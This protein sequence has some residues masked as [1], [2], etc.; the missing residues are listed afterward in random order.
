MGDSSDWIA[1]RTIAP[2]PPS[3]TPIEEENHDADHESHDLAHFRN[4]ILDVAQSEGRWLG[5]DQATQRER[6]PSASRSDHLSI[7]ENLRKEGSR[8]PQLRVRVPSPQPRL[9]APSPVQRVVR[10]LNVVAVPDLQRQPSARSSWV[11]A[12][13]D[14]PDSSS[15]LS[16]TPHSPY[17]PDPV[18][19]RT[20]PP[21]SSGDTFEYL[22]P[23]SPLEDDG[24]SDLENQQNM[25]LSGRTC[26][27]FGVQSNLRRSLIVLL[28]SKGFYYGNI[29]VTLFHMVLLI[30]ET[31]SIYEPVGVYDPG[32]GYQKSW[33][34]IVYMVLFSVYTLWLVAYLVAF[35]GF[36]VQYIF[37]WRDAADYTIQYFRNMFLKKRE[38]SF[39]N[40]HCFF[41]K[42]WNRV[43][44]AGIICYWAYLASGKHE[45]HSL[46]RFLAGLAHLRVLRLLDFFENT[47]V[48]LQALKTALPFLQNV[49]LFIGF[50]LIVFAITGLQSF[51]TS[52]QRHCV[53]FDPQDG[54]NYTTSQKC[55]SWFDGSPGSVKK[56]PYLDSNMREGLTAK[57]F[58]CPLNS[59]CIAG[60]NP[61]GNTV[62]FD[63]FFN[64]LE[65]VFVIM[66][67]NTYSDIMY[68]IMDSE[69]LVSCLFFIS[70]VLV[71][72]I[73]LMNLLVA[74]MLSSFAAVRESM[75]LS[76]TRSLEKKDNEWIYKRNIIGKVYLW[77]HPAI[78][79]LPLVDII[80]QARMDYMKLVQWEIALAVVFSCEIVA[81]FGIFLPFW[82]H[83]LSESWFDC[84]LALANI[85]ILP[86]YKTQVYPWLTVIQLSRA[87]RCV[88]LF[89]FARQ[90]WDQLFGDYMVIINL[91]VFYFSLTFLTSLILVKI[92]RGFFPPSD[93]GNLDRKSFFSLSASFLNM[94][95]I[96]STENWTDIL[97]NA[98]SEAGGLVEAICLGILFCL[99]LAFSNF[100]VLNLFIATMMESMS[101][102]VAI[103]RREQ[104]K[105]FTRELMSYLH[106][107]LTPRGVRVVVE[108]MRGKKSAEPQIG[109]N[110][111]VIQS[112]ERLCMAEFL[113][114]NVL[115]EPKPPRRMTTLAEHPLGRHILKWCRILFSRLRPRTKGFRQNIIGNEGMAFIE[116]MYG[117]A[118]IDDGGSSLFIFSSNH[119]IRRFCQHIFPPSSGIRST[120][121]TPGKRTHS[122]V[123]ALLLLFTVAMVVCT[124]VSTPY[125]SMMQN[126]H[127]GQWQWYRIV[128]LMFAVI[129]LIEFIIKVVADGFHFTPNAY[130]LSPW[131]LVDLVALIS[132]WITF[133]DDTVG[134][135]VSRYSRGFMA[136]RAL[137]LISFTSRTDSVFRAMITMDWKNVVAAVLISLSLVIP[138]SIWGM[139]L[140]ADRL[141]YCNDSD[142][143]NLN[144]CMYEYR[145]SPYNWDIWAPRATVEPYFNYNSF[146]SA[147]LI[148]FGVLSLEGW[149]D[150]MDAVTSIVGIENNEISFTSPGNAA[151]PVLYCFLGTVLIMT[152]FI[153]IVIRNYTVASGTAFLTKDQ[154]AWRDIKRTLRIYKPMPKPPVYPEGSARRFLLNGFGSYGCLS[155]LEILLLA[156][157]TILFAVYFGSLS[158]ATEKS[159]FIA[160]LVCGLALTA[161]CV[162]RFLV[163]KRRLFISTWWNVFGLLVLLLF[164]CSTISIL[165]YG[166]KPKPSAQNLSRVS[167]ILTLTLWIPRVTSLK[168]LISV[169]GACIQDIV[170]LLAT[171]LTFF[172]AYAIAFNQSFGLTKLGENSTQ[173][174][175]FRTVP[176]ALILLFRMSTG[177]GW[178][179]VMEDFTISSPYC[180]EVVKAGNSTSSECGNAALAYFLFITWNVLSMYIFANLLISL[181]VESFWY[182]FQ[183]TPLSGQREV[184]IKNFLKL[185]QEY[186]PHATGYI[187]LRSFPDFLSRCTGYFEMGIYSIDP[188]YS[189]FKIVNALPI[190]RLGD[191]YNLDGQA[192]IRYLDN[193]PVEEIRKRRELYELFCMHVKVTADS[194]G[195]SFRRLLKLFPMY[196]DLDPSKVLTLPEFLRLKIDLYNARMH[197]ATD[198]LIRKWRARHGAGESSGSTLGSPE[199]ESDKSMTLI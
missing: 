185:W 140:F 112:I 60:T 163:M 94:Y 85:A 80:L 64:A 157:L 70:G 102:S 180:Y 109:E 186:D 155:I 51:N 146:G 40:Q 126:V 138:Y 118:P 187:P 191:P 90:L 41:R 178:N 147:L 137:R 123:T 120:R 131:N 26:F 87:Y 27:Y 164:D 91:T 133:I 194:Q 196:K 113:E 160:L 83:F 4:N 101:S 100:V 22:P 24:V 129:F 166:N 176:K 149:V 55:G 38:T 148:Q 32:L 81:R 184:D 18:L 119:P 76:K 6:K 39:V 13:E 25:A 69:Y 17:R 97:Y 36:T 71:L 117:E 34:D 92:L 121:I 46:T 142:I 2:S 5:P 145:A 16:D 158:P 1:L 172:L 72:G 199:T 105:Q 169:L 52:L 75:G 68:D 20:E 181:I 144:D 95:Q 106:A 192:L 193:L 53:W 61:S 132:M 31:R 42:S 104:I 28:T 63:N 21:R 167:C 73:W 127:A 197:L 99:W 67:V 8:T 37:G 107:P 93:D 65:Q 96:S 115:D 7:D 9:R 49:F 165:S 177:E 82:R 54:S 125:Y 98:T 122:V 174:Q 89:K 143:R 15:A 48:V 179:E 198:L 88:A 108:R 128:N 134:G 78:A 135:P 136:F 175:N 47:R 114:K 14:S 161:L 56:R 188:H 151:Y 59:K 10:H 44:I 103:K 190:P 152:M 189:V 84:I 19:G 171:W 58:T 154:I 30:L 124:C 130:T 116:S 173:N 168:R 170:A 45:V 111:E 33:V 74:V 12:G 66:S 141:E 23:G 153:A 162:I 77:I 3:S 195:V 79:I 57:G 183:H 43:E 50:F 35:G 86:C 139:N 159:F 150:V 182:L 29:V 156:I 62:S 11:N 110:N